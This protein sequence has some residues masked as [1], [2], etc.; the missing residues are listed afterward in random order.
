MVVGL[1]VSARR[2]FDLAQ[3]SLFDDGKAYRDYFFDP[4]HLAADREADAVK[5]V[6]RGVSFDV[7]PH[8]AAPLA[9]HLR[10][11]VGHR[12]PDVGS[13]DPRPS[14]PP[15]PDRASDQ[16]WNFG[17]SFFFVARFGLPG[18]SA[19]AQRAL[20]RV[21]TSAGSKLLAAGGATKA[22]NASLQARGM[23]AR[24]GG[25]DAY[26]KFASGAAYQEARKSQLFANGASESYCVIDP[27]DHSLADALRPLL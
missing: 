1:D 10:E 24:F 18:H 5:G 15:V 27:A 3:I 4:I 21:V 13:P 2:N 6:N 9:A 26:R 14:A 7:L 19:D 25:L 20:D 17:K 22:P 8:Y 12:S 16:R 23:V 11:L